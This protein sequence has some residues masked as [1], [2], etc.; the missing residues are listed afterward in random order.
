M[1]HGA[2]AAIGSHELIQL[3]D[4]LE[5]RPIALAQSFYVGELAREI[6]DPVD[7]LVL[8]LPSDAELLRDLAE[9][10]VDLLFGEGIL[11]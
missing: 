6:V 5:H 3:P 1:R 7:D 9:G 8:A 4:D 2:V 10:L 11:D